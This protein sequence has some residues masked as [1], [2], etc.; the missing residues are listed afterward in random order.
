MDLNLRVT[1]SPTTIF[2]EVEGEAVLLNLDRAEY[3]GLDET[4]TRVWELLQE[5]GSTGAIVEQ[6]L[7]EFDVAP[8]R[9]EADLEHL[10]QDLLDNGLIALGPAEP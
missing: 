4:G 2:Q 5:H 8:Q 7:R 6:M 1:P 3:F 9:L 10:L